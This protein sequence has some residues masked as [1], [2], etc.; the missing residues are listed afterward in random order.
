MVSVVHA[1]TAL[2]GS[3]IMMLVFLKIVNRECSFD[4]AIHK[5]GPKPIG[6]IHLILIFI[7][8]ANRVVLL[9]LIF[10]NP[11]NRGY[12]FDVDIY[13]FSQLGMFF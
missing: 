11:V 1:K 9:M 3:I 10:T 5:S 8:L 7:N 6:S 2:T 4:A 12:Y 13:E